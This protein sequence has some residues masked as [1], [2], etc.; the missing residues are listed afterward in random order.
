MKILVISEAI[1]PASSVASIRWTKIG[2]YLNKRF[3]TEVDIL[4]T[5]KRYSE[6]P[7]AAYDRYDLGLAED[8]EYFNE[9]WEIPRG[10][11]HKFVDATFTIIANLLKIIRKTA[12]RNNKNSISDD[13]PNLK[14]SFFKRLYFVFYG[15]FLRI[16]GRSICHHAKEMGI[17]W[18]SY[19]AIITSFSPR[20]VHLLGRWIKTKYPNIIW[21]AD[22][23]DSALSIDDV[24]RNEKRSFAKLYTSKAECV[25]GI[26]QGVIDNLFLPESQ[27]AKVITNG[28]DPEDLSMRKREKSNKFLIS[29]TGTLYS[30]G[31]QVRDLKP[32]FQ[33]LKELI[34]EDELDSEDLLFVYAGSSSDLFETQAGSYRSVFS[35]SDIG[36]VSRSKCYELQNASSLLLLCTW[37]TTEMQG[38]VTGKIF[39]YFSSHV[40][41]VG[42]CSGDLSCSAIKE[43]L[44]CANA[45]FCYEE[46]N[47]EIDFFDLKRFIA[48]KY[49]EWKSE[50]F[51]RSEMNYQYINSFKY[52][53]IAKQYHELFLELDRKASNT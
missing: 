11:R 8:L 18:D 33:A 20:W 47:K 30:Q 34:Q 24:P 12:H 42:L 10:V 6:I 28:F 39:E 52:D 50:G 23:R 5:K 4:T 48:S 7:R 9:V 44:T 15:N 22:Y 35:I 1:A 43:I 32:C 2:K 13:E 14:L 26:S 31:S 25:T 41:I 17:E 21:I 36:F 37:N 53:Y 40:P 16:K 27:K 51:T 38:V 3:N 49:K 19:D 29:Y 46:A 45:G